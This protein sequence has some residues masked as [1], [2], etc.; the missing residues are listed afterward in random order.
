MVNWALKNSMDLSLKGRKALVCGASKGLGYASAFSLASLGCQV[1][2]LSRTTSKL[3]EAKNHLEAAYPANH[4]YISCDLTKPNEVKR[5]LNDMDG[6]YHI[7]VLNSGGPASGPLIQAS[8]EDL[9]ATFGSFVLS[10]HLL[11]Q[12]VY[13]HM[14]KEAFGR[15]LTIM[16]IGMKEPI[17]GLGVSNT[18]R[19]AVGN[20]AKTLATELG[21]DGITVNNLL[22]GY[23]LTD[24]LDGLMQKRAED[25]GITKE[26]MIQKYIDQIPLRKLA[27]PEDLGNVVAFLATPAAHYIN[28]SN[29][30]VDGG[31]MKSL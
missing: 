9:E 30:P 29:I 8:I 26:E 4:D 2:L 22:A 12:K 11:V 19:G 3:I 23:T 21:P 14:K 15:I 27:I 24:R 20:W 18:I 28:G 10:N 7:L 16:S 13:P 17:I 1:T 25:Q 6:A 31:Y 5:M